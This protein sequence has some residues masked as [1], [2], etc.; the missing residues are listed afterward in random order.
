MDEALKLLLTYGPG[1]LI[2]ALVILGVLVPKAFFDREVKRGDLAT[3]AAHNTSVAFTTVIDA[4]KAV[5]GMVTELN[6]DVSD[7]TTEIRDLRREVAEL[8]GKGV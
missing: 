3:A 4:L 1:G 6:K 7:L 8:R 5:T 2:A